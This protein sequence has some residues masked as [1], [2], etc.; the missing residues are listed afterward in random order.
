MLHEPADQAET[1]VTS[2]TRYE[3]FGS[4]LFVTPWA[5]QLSCFFLYTFFCPSGRTTA[6]F[7][8]KQDMADCF[9]SLVAPPAFEVARLMG[10][11]VL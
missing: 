8:V 1:T 5:I 6:T 11:E 3:I 4:T 2:G 7:Q 10:Y 9:E